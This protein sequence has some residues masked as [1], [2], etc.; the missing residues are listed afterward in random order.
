MPKKTGY[1]ELDMIKIEILLS[2]GLFFLGPLLLCYRFSDFVWISV[3][4]LG[5]I[6]FIDGELRLIGGKYRSSVFKSGRKFAIFIVCSFAGVA[7]FIMLYIF[8][9]VIIGPPI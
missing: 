6:L 3:I 5:A 2:I 8:V 9:L 7:L 1:E 4:G